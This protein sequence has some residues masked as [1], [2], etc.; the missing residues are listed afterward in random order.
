[1]T[2]NASSTT[3]DALVAA[4][5][6]ASEGAPASAT[7]PV[8]PHVRAEIDL[9][10]VHLYCGHEAQAVIS[11]RSARALLRACDGL[12][13]ADALADLEEAAW[14]ARNGRV[15]PAERALERALM[16]A[17]LMASPSTAA[18]A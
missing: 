13:H 9:A 14:L 1:M 4:A 5:G 12:A 10:R 15:E 3:I 7:A 17:G 18:Q 2:F 8:D 16:H 11:I 6:H